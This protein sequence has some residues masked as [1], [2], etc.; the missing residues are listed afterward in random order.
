VIYL[1]DT[2][3]FSIHLRGRCPELSRKLT[4]HLRAD[5]IRLSMIVL[6]ELE[7]GARKARKLG[8]SRPASRVAILRKA[9]PVEPLAETVSDCY[10]KLRADLESKGR[11][12]GG[13]DMLLAAHALSLDATVITRKVGEFSR[14][15]GLR[16]EDWQGNP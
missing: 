13:M 1:P 3:A 11:L 16:V 9:V 7:Y 2:N 4:E 10:G 12:I 15:A 8:E 14:I 5:E 6:C